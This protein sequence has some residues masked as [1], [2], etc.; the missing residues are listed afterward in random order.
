M[1]LGIATLVPAAALAAD[2]DCQPISIECSGFEPN[3]AFSLGADGTIVFTDPENPDWQ[4]HPLTLRAC[5]RSPRRGLIEISVA[6]SLALSASVTAARCTE[7]ND[8]VQPYEISISF[9]QGAATKDA[10]AVTGTGCC[11]R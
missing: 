5:A 10:R 7:P 11:R 1:L 4:T 2:R 9:R 8:A 3:W 6:G